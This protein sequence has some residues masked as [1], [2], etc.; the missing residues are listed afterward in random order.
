MIN[1]KRLYGCGV[2]LALVAL[3]A[4]A[5]KEPVAAPE[6]AAEEET[7][8]RTEFTQRVENFFEYVPLKVNKASIFRIHLTD[9]SD[10]SPVSQAQVTL[11]VRQSGSSQPAAEVTA[12]I[13]K[14]TGIYV[15]ELTLKQAGNYD[16]EFHIKNDK[17]DERLPLTGFKTE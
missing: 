1:R 10:G 15:A 7:H 8:A 5:K 9:L 6:A 14:V 2:L 17:L 12:K 11:T 4:C 13:G 16:I 3:T